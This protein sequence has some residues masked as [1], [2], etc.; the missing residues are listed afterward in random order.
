MVIYFE[1]DGVS[2]EITEQAS[3]KE[4]FGRGMRRTFLHITLERPTIKEVE[5]PPAMIVIEDSSEEDQKTTGGSPMMVDTD[6]EP[7][8]RIKGQ[9]EEDHNDEDPLIFKHIKKTKIGTIFGTSENLK[10]QERGVY[11]DAQHGILNG[12]GP[13]DPN[14][15]IW[16]EIWNEELARAFREHTWVQGETKVLRNEGAGEEMGE[17]KEEF[18][19]P[20][21]PNDIVLAPRININNVIG[22]N[23]YVSDG[24]DE[25][26]SIEWVDLL[27]GNDSE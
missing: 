10:D 11:E 8:Q 18:I 20:K 5:P 25:E 14:P 9:R 6:E 7:E 3:I 4:E 16:E 26:E 17:S 15:K 24:E 19:L 13:S 27:H 1:M 22:S 23:N 12:E 2:I 21:D